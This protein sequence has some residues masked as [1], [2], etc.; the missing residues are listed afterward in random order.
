MK[1]I[2]YDGHD[3]HFRR[4]LKEY[5]RFCGFYIRKSCKERDKVAEVMIKFCRFFVLLYIFGEIV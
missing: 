4:I 1:N 3:F 5:K 2:Y